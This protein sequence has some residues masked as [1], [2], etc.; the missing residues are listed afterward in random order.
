MALIAP[1]GKTDGV[2][3]AAVA[4]RDSVRA[5]AFAKRHR[6]PVVHSSYDDLIA[7]PDIDLIYNPL[8]NGLHGLWSV[9]AMEAGKDV[10]CE[11]PLAANAAEARAMVD[12]AARTGRRVI[13]AFHYRYHP[14]VARVKEILASGEIGA[15]RRYDASFVV[16]IVRGGDIRYNYDLAGGGCMDLGCY[17]IH[18]IRTLAEAEPTVKKATAVEAPA[19]IDRSM[20]AE[21]AFAD[22][23]SARMRCSMWSP[24]VLRLGTHIEGES[25]SIDV[26]NFVAPQIFNWVRVSTKDGT[27]RERIS[28]PASYTAQL[29]AVVDAVGDGT[30]LPTEGEDSI[31]NMRVIDAIYGAAGLPMRRPTAL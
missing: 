2:T 27:R 12:A 25:G 15:V 20:D 17:P 29:R 9:R 3:V 28:G 6:I 18:F 26:F 7:D 16:P 8:P 23:R 5:A 1:A 10:L 31:A 14:L 4:A 19:N 21:L 13:E 22:G 11:K 30:P 24:R